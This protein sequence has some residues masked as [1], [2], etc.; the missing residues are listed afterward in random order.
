MNPELR[1]L[2]WLEAAPARLVLVPAVLF[3]LLAA[4]T[5]ADGRDG[6]AEAAFWATAALG[7]V[8]G[9]RL[10]AQSLLA[11]IAANTWDG[12]RAGALS[13]W[14]MTLGKLAGSTAI[15]WYGVAL[16]AIGA[17]VLD[18]AATPLEEWRELLLLAL[19]AQAA[20]L[21]AALL[22]AAADR[23][24]RVIDGFAAQL[25]GIGAGFLGQ[26]V[27]ALVFEE[28]ATF[29]GT[30]VAPWMA[31]AVLAV[32]AALAVGLAWWRMGEALQTYAG[33]WVWPLFLLVVVLIAGGHAYGSV[34]WSAAAFTW[35]LPIGWLA[36]LIDPKQPVA[37]RAWIRRPT[38]HDAPSW[39][40]AFAVLVVLAGAFVTG[41]FDPDL[42]RPLDIRPDWMEWWDW[43]VATLPALA[44]F[45]RDAALMHLVAWGGLPGRGIAGVLIHVAI[46]YGLLPVIVA[47]TIGEG[48]LWLLLPIPGAP[49]LPALA[50]PLAQAAVLGILAWRRLALLVPE[51]R[52]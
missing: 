4:A 41:R 27:V 51:N 38:R 49:L 34:P 45:L 17:A 23:R 8:W 37:L 44:F 39:L 26:G 12:Q 13:A 3:L 42:P 7:V 5:L 9:T 6:G 24:G 2:L 21:F 18:P 40:V 10:A 25:A 19:L 15:A 28:A 47:T 33:F 20:S 1:R 16:C 22:L 30:A 50:A 35:L 46:L 31:P 36:L 29:W 52:R 43:R 32:L 11:E 14:Q 48:R